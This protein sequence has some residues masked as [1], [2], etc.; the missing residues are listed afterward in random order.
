MDCLQDS[1][2]FVISLNKTIS[3]YQLSS[4]ILNG[5]KGN[6]FNGDK[7]FFLFAMMNNLGKEVGDIADNANPFVLNVHILLLL[8]GVHLPR[9]KFSV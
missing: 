7:F 3:G 5:K 8:A 6:A 2:L 9:K 1:T 4:C